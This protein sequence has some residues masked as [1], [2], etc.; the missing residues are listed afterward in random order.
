MQV[1]FLGKEGFMLNTDSQEADAPGETSAWFPNHRAGPGLNLLVEEHHG[2]EVSPQA[3]VTIVCNCI[4]FDS[5]HHQP[6]NL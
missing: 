3:K 1:G 6:P 5:F 2:E 4:S